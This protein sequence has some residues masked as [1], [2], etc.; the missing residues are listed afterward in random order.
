MRILIGSAHFGG[1]HDSIAFILKNIIEDFSKEDG[2]FQTNIHFLQGKKA[3]LSYRLFGPTSYF[4]K[5]FNGLNNLIGREIILTLADTLMKREIIKTLKTYQ[6]EIV[7]SVHSFYTKTLS[8][9]KVKN[10]LFVADPFTVHALWAETE[11]DK[12]VVFT[13]QAAAKLEKFYVP[14]EKIVITK[15]PLRDQFYRAP[16]KEKARSMLGITNNKLVIVFGG[17]GDG[18]DKTKQIISNLCKTDLDFSAFVIC[19]RN[20]FLKTTLTAQLFNDERFHIMGIVENIS[21][22][23]SAA[24][25]FVGKAGPNIL[26]ECCFLKTPFIATPPFLP[27]EEGNRKFIL[28]NKIG[29]VEQNPGKIVEIIKNLCDNPSLIKPIR[30]KMD[31]IRNKY[32]SRQEEFSA[33]IKALIKN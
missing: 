2:Q 14:K 20:L 13:K 24:D 12:I 26:F 22:Y 23:L 7:L 19:G 21:L 18:M 25:V 1:G 16:E 28:S 17:S 3:S 30:T 6:P 32:I 8:R 27:Q 33:A 9:M 29:W 11:S 31:K 4:N 15:F 5:S 10:V